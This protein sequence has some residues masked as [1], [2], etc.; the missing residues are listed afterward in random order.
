MGFLPRRKLPLC[1]AIS[2]VPFV[3]GLLVTRYP[4]AL[5]ATSVS[6]AM[7]ALVIILF[8]RLKALRTAVGRLNEAAESSAR[9][10]LER[11]ARLEEEL[12]VQAQV[13]E[14]ERSNLGQV[15]Y[16]LADVR[17]A[18]AELDG[19]VVSLRQEVSQERTNLGM[20]A[21]GVDALWAQ[22]HAQGE[23]ID[24]ERDNLGSVAGGLDELRRATVGLDL[25]SERY[26][27]LS[28]SLLD[29]ARRVDAISDDLHDLQKLKLD[30]LPR[31]VQ[32]ALGRI[33]DVNLEAE[34][35]STQISRLERHTGLAGEDDGD[36]PRRIETL[37][38]E[39]AGAETRLRSLD[40]DLRGQFA[41]LNDH[42]LGQGASIE[43]LMREA[44]RRDHPDDPKDK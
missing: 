37:H 38:T 27:R 32:Q 41:L 35:V 7:V 10:S 24:R 15:A 39:L 5:L 40:H 12:A 3:V 14:Q 43:T 26:T 30:E 36:L 1:I 42:V 9:H 11:I 19:Q 29:M 31:T 4:I 16:G 17:I 13:G 34:A 6:F 28:D 20:I 22:S 21:E 44:G 18:L 2:L 8:E 25:A 33:D 23:A